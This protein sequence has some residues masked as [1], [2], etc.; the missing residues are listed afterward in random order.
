MVLPP[1]ANF[2][3]V[4]AVLLRHHRRAG[5]IENPHLATHL[6]PGE[7]YIQPATKTCDCGTWLGSG[8]PRPSVKRPERSVLDKLRLK[9]WS[10]AKIDRWIA[11]RDEVTARNTRS[12]ADRKTA[13]NGTDPDGWIS[14]ASELLALSGV[15]YVGI[16]L[17]HYYGTLVAERLSIAGRS[18]LKLDES[19][20]DA[21]FNIEEDRIYEIYL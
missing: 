4:A 13:I 8:C 3:E 12:D 15:N 7:L 16:L 21:L 6:R 11:Q 18:K 14:T 5:V 1:K 9:G 19:L 2:K 10:Q 20:S 17:H